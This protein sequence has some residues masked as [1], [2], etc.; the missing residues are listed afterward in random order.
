MVDRPMMSILRFTILTKSIQDL[1]RSVAIDTFSLPLLGDRPVSSYQ[2]RFVGIK[3]HSVDTARKWR[4][5]LYEVI[6]VD[7][8]STEKRE[9]RSIASQIIIS[10]C[11][12]EA[13]WPCVMEM[14][15][16]LVHFTS[17]NNVRKH[18]HPPDR[19]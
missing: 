11:I 9:N 5:R 10:R 17:V 16:E 8:N 13:G 1:S 14:S 3:L 18:N 4:K 2:L 7:Y 19:H 15:D 6:N 12:Y